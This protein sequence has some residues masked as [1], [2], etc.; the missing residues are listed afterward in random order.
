MLLTIFLMGFLFQVEEVS[1]ISNMLVVFIMIVYRILLDGF[2]HLFVAVAKL[3]KM[4]VLFF[5][6]MPCVC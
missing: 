5:S 6:L 2:S 1:S 4:I 3:L